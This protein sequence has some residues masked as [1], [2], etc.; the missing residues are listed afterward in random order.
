MNNI[1]PLTVAMGLF[2]TI[3]ILAAVSAVFPEEGVALTDTTTLRF[4]PLHEVLDGN[5]NSTE[6]EQLSPEQLLALRQQEM[7][8]SEEQEFLNYFQT[9][10][11]RIHFP[12]EDL[13]YFDS[14]YMALNGADTS[15][16]RI[17]HYGDSQLEE[18]RISCNLRLALQ[19]QFGGG[20]NGLIPAQEALYSQTINLYSPYHP[21]RYMVY[22]P[23]SG[24]RDSSF[25]YG[26]MGA[27]SILDSTMVLSIT[28]KKRQGE[29]TASHYFNSLTVLHRPTGGLTLSV[30]GQ[31]VQVAADGSAMQRSC[32]HLKDSTTQV[33]LTLSGKAD[34]YGIILENTTGV[35][36]DNIPMRG[37]SGTIFTGISSAQ[38]RDYLS[39]GDVHLIIMQFGG[40][41]MPY[42]KDQKG[43]DRYMSSLR[44]QVRHIKGLAPK[45]R[46]LW[47]GP[48]DMTTRIN[49][50]MQ[51]Y[52]MLSAMDKSICKMVNEEGCAY[53]SLFE[54][55]GGTGS[56]IRWASAQPP[57]A[58]KD[59]V[60]FTRLGAQRAG[61]LLTEA[62]LMG[63]KYFAFRQPEM[64]AD[65]SAVSVADSIA[66]QP[67]AE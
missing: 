48:S 19:Q 44:R 38:L 3:G 61:E 24:R 2:A 22:G 27:V 45:A 14:V 52:P 37:C 35:T 18:D 65:T 9:N 32:F 21:T 51:T 30:Q 54:S 4:P 36:V 63:Y 34:I 64:P 31:R 46:I 50:K 49:G 40:N 58:G 28:P 55:M 5:E 26:P 67:I 17:V 47:V 29:L 59:Y 16:V 23:K 66:E 56:M 20:G 25:F 43:I 62:F 53:W 1:R 11:V 60:H 15:H 41:T 33:S 57:L 7:H 8:I 42:I 12:S 39:A 10:P 6:A 13:T